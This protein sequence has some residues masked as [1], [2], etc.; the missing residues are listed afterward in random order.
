L[1]ETSDIAGRSYWDHVWEGQAIPPAL[2]PGEKTRYNAADQAFHDLFAR[3]FDR[4]DQSGKQL[5]EVGAARSAWLP[6][7]ALRYGFNIAGIDYSELG[8]AQARAILERDGIDGR[9]VLSDF[10][11]PPD[12]MLAAFD[13]VISFGVVEHFDETAACVEAL[14]RFLRPG[15]LMIT[16]VPNLRGVGGFL[17]KRLC[18]A[19]YDV[20]VRLDRQSLRAAHERAGLSV[21]TSR[22]FVSGGFTTMNMSCWSESRFYE[23]ISRLPVAL[24]MPFLLLESINVRIRANRLTSPYLICLAQKTP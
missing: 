17:Q 20:H 11:A 16:V 21:R 5:L 14:A 6:Y 3:L 23:T 9:V 10:F 4:T 19:I 7:F 13:V 18:R 1:N 2:T 12:D 22:Y 24:T 15:G 8:C